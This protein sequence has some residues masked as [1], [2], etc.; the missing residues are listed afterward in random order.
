[1]GIFKRRKKKAEMYKNFVLALI[2]VVERSVIGKRKIIK[3]SVSG[4]E[5]IPKARHLIKK[6]ARNL[7][8]NVKNVKKRWVMVEDTKFIVEEASKINYTN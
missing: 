5:D 8:F 7:G 1:M 4:R 3:F 2:N 6:I